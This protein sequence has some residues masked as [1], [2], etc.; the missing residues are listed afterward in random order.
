MSSKRRI[1][2]NKNNYT[3]DCSIF[4]LNNSSG[5][6]NTNY[7]RVKKMDKYGQLSCKSKSKSNSLDNYSQIMNFSNSIKNNKF[8]SF[9]FINKNKLDYQMSKNRSHQ[10]SNII[11]NMFNTE[12]SKNKS[13]SQKR[14]TDSMKKKINNYKNI[15][16]NIKNNSEVLDEKKSFKISLVKPNF[17]LKE[18]IIRKEKF[19]QKILSEKIKPLTKMTFCYY[20][21]YHTKLNR[22]NPLFNIPSEI[23]CKPPYHFANATISLAKSYDKIKIAPIDHLKRIEFIISDIENTI[24]SSKTKLIIEVHRNYR[25]FKEIN[26]D[27]SMNDFIKSQTE[28]YPNLTEEEIEK[29]AKNKN[30]NFSLMATGGK[31]IELIICSYQ[32]FKAWIN[33]LAFLIKNKNEI[34]QCIKEYSN[35]KI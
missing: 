1:N 25:K 16:Q 18:K 30:Y 5:K 13:N 20:R 3:G 10:K 31:I 34:I 32:E 15:L 14:N 7:I 11:F 24:V 21:I 26:N 9:S 29:C 4:S 33:G 2:N 19:S 12:N 8:Q 35:N 28:K 22:Y 6:N 27:K 17:N 23:L